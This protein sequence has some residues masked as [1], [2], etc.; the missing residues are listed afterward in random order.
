MLIY[1]FSGNLYRTFANFETSLKTLKTEQLK[2]SSAVDLLDNVHVNGKK[3]LV[4]LTKDVYSNRIA[5][6]SSFAIFRST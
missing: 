3:K 5:P 4:Q 1:I 6:I 2:L